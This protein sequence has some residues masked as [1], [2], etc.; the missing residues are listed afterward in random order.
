VTEPARWGGR[1]RALDLLDKVHLARPAVRL[2]ELLLA[3]KAQALGRAD[4]VNGQLPL[5]PPLLRTQIG[6]AHAD[7]AVFLRSGREHADLIERLLAADGSSVADLDSCLDFGCGCG[8]VLRHWSRLPRTRVFGCDIDRRMVAWCEAHLPFADVRVTPLAP[9][10]PYEDDAFDLVYAFSVFTH[11]PEDLQH[12]WIGELTRVTGEGGRIVFSTLGEHY[13]GLDRLTP[14]EEESFR[15]GNVVVLYQGSPGTS[16]CSAYHPREYVVSSLA[17]HLE[18]VAFEPAADD[19]RHDV[20]VFR[21]PECDQPP[22]ASSAASTT[23]SAAR[24]STSPTT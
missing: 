8:R 24:P 7:A 6:P 3:T 19:A 11:L 15:A 5:P 2:Y 22:I 23:R 10:L 4:D 9:P 14:P 18:L 17:S 20:Y 1:R 13:L 12:G 21:K 16:L